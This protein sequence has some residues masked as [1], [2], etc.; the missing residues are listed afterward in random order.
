MDFTPG[1]MR[2]V[3]APDYAQSNST[4]ASI[5][6][7]CHQLAMF[8]IYSAPLQML[9]DSPSAYR[10][11]PDYLRFLSSIPATWDESRALES[12]I[13]EQV[14]IARRRGATWYVGILGGASARTVHLDLSFLGAGAHR[15]TLVSDGINADKLPTEYGIHSLTVQSGQR[16]PVILAPGGGAV[17][18][19]DTAYQDS[20]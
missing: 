8:V 6:T 11:A 12:R 3:S 17:L 13:G 10:Q 15:A 16:L 9:C 4:P 5:G 14:V 1:A 20:K 18:R 19:I 2:N 7:R